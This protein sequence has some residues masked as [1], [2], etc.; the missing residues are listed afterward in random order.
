MTTAVLTAI[1]ADRLIKLLGML[2]SRH[3]GERASA[4]LMADRLV[5]EH[6]L[7][8]SDVIVVPTPDRPWH[9]MALRCHSHAHLFNTREFLFI[10]SML[11]WRGEL[12]AK[13]Q[14]WLIDLFV[15]AGGTR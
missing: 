7:T 15:R 1:D 3:D 2:G 8:W 12:S 10:N 6:G 14:K 11:G 4:A 9:K 5:R 13:Q